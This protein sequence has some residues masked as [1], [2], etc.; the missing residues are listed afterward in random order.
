[1]SNK[2]LQNSAVQLQCLFL[3]EEIT[4]KY[5]EKEKISSK[6]RKIITDL[7]TV[8]NLIEWTRIA[9]KFME[10]NIKVCR[11]VEQIQSYKISELMGSKLKH[12][13]EE[14]IHNFSS[15]NLST[16]EKSLLC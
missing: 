10:S 14:V 7:I 6:L 11:K 4:F 2:R 3:Q 16:S 1:M 15:Y 5:V 12:N 8:I 9:N 13:P